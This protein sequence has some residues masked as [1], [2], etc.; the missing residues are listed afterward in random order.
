LLFVSLI[1]YD[2][3]CSEPLNFL[4][5]VVE[6]AM[7]KNAPVSKRCFVRA[8]RKTTQFLKSIKSR[9]TQA[10]QLTVVFGFNIEAFGAYSCKQLLNVA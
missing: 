1:R 4:A 2:F 6:V 8:C 5:V 3:L 7:Y 10:D 9:F